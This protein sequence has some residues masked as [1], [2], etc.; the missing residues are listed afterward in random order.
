MSNQPT[1]EQIQE[2][3]AALAAGQKIEA[4][5]IYREATGEG[6]KEAK[7]FID[8]LV[9]K[10]IEQDPEKY[11]GLSKGSGCAS[12]LVLCAGVTVLAVAMLVKHAG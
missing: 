4:I 3:G 7:E 8:A 1:E 12:V 9:P 10:L 6:L 11:A 2:I 5:K